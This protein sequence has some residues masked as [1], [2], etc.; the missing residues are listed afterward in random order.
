MPCALDVHIDGGNIR[1]A[2]QYPLDVLEAA[3]HG[4][5]IRS[6]DRRDPS[7]MFHLSVPPLDRDSLRRQFER[8]S[9]SVLFLPPA[10]T[11]FL[12]EPSGARFVYPMA[13]HPLHPERACHHSPARSD[14]YGVGSRP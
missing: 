6:N 9:L 10:R 7:G 2:S 4:P 12:A 11:L 3:G 14:L 5:E 8:R 13:T 1:A